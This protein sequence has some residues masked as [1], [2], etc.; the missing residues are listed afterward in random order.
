MAEKFIR[1]YCY[2]IQGRIRLLARIHRIDGTLGC[3]QVR[4]RRQKPRASHKAVSGMLSNHITGHITGISVALAICLVSAISRVL[5][6][7]GIRNISPLTATVVSMIVGFVAL[8]A[9][10]IPRLSQTWSELPISGVLWYLAIGLVA[11]P[12][13]RGLTYVGITKIGVARTDQVRASQPIFA[14]LF[15][16]LLLQEAPSLIWYLAAGLI[17]SGVYILLMEKTR[18]REEFHFENNGWLFPLTAAALAGLV[19][20]WRKSGITYLADPV[21]GAF[22]AALSGLTVGLAYLAVSGRWRELITFR[23]N[24]K[25]L[26][27][28]GVL[29][30]T[31]DILDLVA[32]KHADVHVIAPVLGSAPLFST[33]VSGYLLKE[34]AITKRTWLASIIIFIGIQAAFFI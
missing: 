13:V 7:K 22:F 4:G 5:L 27:L 12:V 2:E 33:L 15:A 17:L 18:D 3:H 1:K 8:A 28:A 16:S 6:K 21:L 9:I 14:A 10:A 31:T 20:I 23:P 34:E 25:F 30:A 19:M 11:P 32:L 26:L 29:T 24:L